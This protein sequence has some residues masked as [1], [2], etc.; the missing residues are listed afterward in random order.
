M[1]CN[2]TV[3]RIQVIW[4][5]IGGEEMIDALI[6]GRAKIEVKLTKVILS[7]LGTTNTSATDEKFIAKEKF[8]MNSKE[9]R[10][11]GIW[12]NF[13]EWYLTGDGV[14]DEVMGAQSIC[15]ADLTQDCADSLIIKEFGGEKK[16]ET[17][18]AELYDLL[19]KQGNGE[20]GVLLTNGRANIFYIKNIFG[21]LCVVDVYWCSVGWSVHSDSFGGISI[22][23]NDARVFS[24]KS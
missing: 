6:T 24:R 22:R 19:K 9:V 7:S 16:S 21:V 3:D 4:N 15:F 17:T 20:D 2:K 13:N 1:K 18:L 14:V 23:E 10:F 12:E 11:H 5:M 8:V